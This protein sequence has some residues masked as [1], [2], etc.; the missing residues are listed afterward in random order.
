M[1]KILV[2]S[3]KES[4][5]SLCVLS[6][7]DAILDTADGPRIQ[8]PP[9]LESLI[10]PNTLFLLNKAD[11]SGSA[12]PVRTP[13]AKTWVASLNTGEGTEKFLDNFAAALR[14]R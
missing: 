12:L 11:L 4:D 8:I 14:E 13:G 1:L 5:V 9:S 6:L 3:V 2:F 7:P 10:T